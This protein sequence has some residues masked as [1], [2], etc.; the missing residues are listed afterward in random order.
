[1]QGEDEGSKDLGLKFDLTVPLAR[2]VATH[3][4]NLIFP[5]RRYQIQPVFRGERAQKGRYRQ[6]YQCDFDIIKRES[7]TV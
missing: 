5:F 2:Y 6:F 7:F 1:M 3:F 4:H